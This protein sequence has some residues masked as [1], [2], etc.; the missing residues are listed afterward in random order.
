MPLHFWLLA[1]LSLAV[2][3]FKYL[4]QAI[5][6]PIAKTF[7]FTARYIDDIVSITTVNNDCSFMDIAKNIYPVSLELSQTS[8]NDMATFLD[9]RLSIDSQNKLKIDIYN[10]TD[11]FSFPVVRYMSEV[12]NVQKSIGYN[13]FYGEI[14]RFARITN[15]KASFVQRSKSLFQMFLNKGFKKNVLTNVIKKLYGAYYALFFKFHI[16]DLQ[17]FLKNISSLN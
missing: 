14:L 6:R 13:T 4:N 8:A 9:A 15:N 2:L 7:T 10:K 12:N 16:Y 11:D 5:N 1:D 3:E 17:S